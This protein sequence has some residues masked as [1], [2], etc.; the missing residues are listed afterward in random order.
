MVFGTKGI[1]K[2]AQKVYKTEN[3]GYFSHLSVMKPSN[4]QNLAF[5]P[6]GTMKSKRD[7]YSLRKIYK[8]KFT[9]M[10]LLGSN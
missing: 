6:L 9:L 1:Y 8:G 2:G 5:Q 4:H 7:K 10:P 3:K